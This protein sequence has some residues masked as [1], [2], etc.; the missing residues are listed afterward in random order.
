MLAFDRVT[1]LLGLKTQNFVL[2]PQWDECPFYR[3]HLQKSPSI[4]HDTCRSI[5]REFERQLR[6]INIEYASK[7]DSG[8]LQPVQLNILPPDWL[9]RFDQEEASRQRAGNE[10]YKHKFL[11]SD[12]G[13]DLE[14][15]LYRNQLQ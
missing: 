11:L 15:P 4:S 6:Q 5:A 3:L 13:A 10:Q 12:I 7:R 14:F 9:N 1:E 2:A 8:R